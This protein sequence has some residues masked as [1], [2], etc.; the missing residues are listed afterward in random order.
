MYISKIRDNR[1]VTGA[2]TCTITKLVCKKYNYIYY[3][4]YY[5]IIIIYYPKVLY[6]NL[7]K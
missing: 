5:N 7:N 2:N 6:S 1:K 3:I 4:F